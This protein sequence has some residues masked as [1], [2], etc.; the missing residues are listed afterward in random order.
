MAMH[1]GLLYC[2]SDRSLSVREAKTGRMIVQKKYD[3]ELKNLSTPLVTDREIIFGTAENGVV[4][5]D[6]STLE[7]KWRFRTGRAMIYTVPTLGDP[8]SPIET[9]PVL[10]GNI[11]Y[12]GASDGYLYAL[13]R[14]T[15]QLLWK[16]AMG[17][18]V[19]GTV[20]VSGNALFAVD[21]SGNIYG[22]V[23]QSLY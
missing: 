10:S 8:A 19:L 11:V 14:Q 1:S 22:F 13:D 23:S 21:F 17:A 2:L 4:A 6:A 20:A 5:V 15:G 9:S 12:V 3:F 16:H 7:V 18:P